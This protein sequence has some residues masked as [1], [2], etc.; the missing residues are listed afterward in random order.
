MGHGQCTYQRT[1]IKINEDGNTGRATYITT[2]T[3]CDC[4]GFV[5]ENFNSKTKRACLWCRHDYNCIEAFNLL[6]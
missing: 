2:T 4:P 3:M 1:A 5:Q 6:Q